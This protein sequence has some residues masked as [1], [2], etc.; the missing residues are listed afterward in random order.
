MSFIEARDGTPLFYKD[1]G[2]GKPVVLVHGWPLN[3]DMWE[4]QAPFLAENGCRVIAYDRRG[5]GRSGQPW[6]GY[7]YDTMADDLAALFDALDLRDATLVGFSM[8]GGEV[9]RYLSRHGGS[10]R[11]SRAVLVSAVTPF[12]LRTENNPDGVDR[13]VFDDMVVNLQADRP[14]FLASFGKQFFGAG[15]LNFSISSE[16]LQWAGNLALMASPKATLDCVRA[17]SETDF[18]AD[19]PQIRVPVLVIHGDADGTVPIDAAGRRAAAMIPGARL[20][21]YK[22]APHGLFFTEK[23]RLNQDLLRF[24]GG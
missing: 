14:A 3:A 17:F 8:G 4:Y 7:D 18:R 13:S 16:L 9:A 19:L 11:V 6:S 1:W 21:E 12:L 24:I 22:G 2:A 15:L 23:D 10:G 20:L 5:F